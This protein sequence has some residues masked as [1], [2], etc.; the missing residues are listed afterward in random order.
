MSMLFTDVSTQQ[1]RG[2]IKR[3][4]HSYKAIRLMAALAIVATIPISTWA[5]DEQSKRDTDV[6]TVDVA[7]DS[8]TL[9]VN[10]VDPTQPPT[11][12]LPG[13]TLVIEGTIYPGGTL[14]S[15]LANNDPNATGEIGKIRCR[16]LV[17]VPPTDLTTPTAT[18]V[19]ELYSFPD[20]NRIIIADGPGANLFATVLRAV[21]GGTR[22]FDGA[23]GQ[24]VEKNLGVNKSG[25]CNLRITFHLKKSDGSRHFN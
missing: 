11:A 2:S 4:N 6:F 15:G 10:H 14:P 16:A 13:D 18:F 22:S 8:A 1:E 12:Q 5:D 24:L 3:L 20:D 19:T 21:V 9:I 23:S 7:L 25:A 17:L